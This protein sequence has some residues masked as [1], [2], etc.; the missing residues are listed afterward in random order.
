MTALLLAAVT[1]AL[2]ADLGRQEQDRLLPSASPS[3]GPQAS[4]THAEPSSPAISVM[5]PRGRSADFQAGMTLVVYANSP[6]LGPGAAPLLDRLADLGVNSLSVAFPFYQRSWTS[7]TVEASTDT[8][9]SPQNLAGLMR[10]ARQ[11]HFTLMLRPLIDEQSLIADG[12]WRGSLRPSSVRGW[13][14]SYAGMV[15]PYA[16]LAQQERVEILCV[17]TELVSLEQHTQEWMDLIAKV[18]AVFDGLLTYCA[19]WDSFARPTFWDALDFVGVD[20]FFPLNAPAQASV[21]EMLAAWRPWAQR[22]EQFQRSVGKPIVLTEQGVTSQRG[23]HRQPWLWDQ[24]TPIDLEGQGRYYRA[25]C[26]AL[27]GVVSGM[28]WWAVELGVP[29]GPAIDAGYSPLA[30]P[31][32]SEIR[33]C[34]V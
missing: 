32:E 16:A 3:T 9:P 2:T 28:Y 5:K 11:R 26:E 30:K 33:R 1:G 6:D 22:L 13:F 34:F 17:G 4:P 25:T 12:Q 15:L 21:E 10:A 31:A 14:E 7:S 19:N 8:T 20:G 29:N 27:R 18:R 23:S 24:G